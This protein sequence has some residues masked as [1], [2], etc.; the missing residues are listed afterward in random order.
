MAPQRLVRVECMAHPE[1]EGIKA[2][3]YPFISVDTISRTLIRAA[4]TAIY[5]NFY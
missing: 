4:V 3:N 5:S 1:E 2:E